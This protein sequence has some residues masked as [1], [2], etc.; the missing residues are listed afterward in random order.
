M[1][2]YFSG[3]PE[4]R[5]GEKHIYRVASVAPRLGASPIDAVCVTCSK[6]TSP[7]LPPYQGLGTA[8]SRLK[9]HS[10]YWN[11]DWNFEDGLSTSTPSTKFQKKKKRTYFN[12]VV[13]RNIVKF[14]KSY[15]FQK[16]IQCITRHTTITKKM[17]P[18]DRKLCKIAYIIPHHLVR[19]RQSILF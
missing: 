5:S 11:T 3:I 4:K 6:I 1:T 7:P 9:Q 10:K 15:P 17:R 16:L 14:F 13:Y 18:A 12:I 8:N 19:K 2:R